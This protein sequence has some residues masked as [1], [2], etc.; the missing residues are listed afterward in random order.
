MF[1]R[2]DDF[3]KIG[4]LSGK[5]GQPTGRKSKSFQGAAGRWFCWQ[6]P[7]SDRMAT[8]DV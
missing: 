4:Y 2:F 8:L 7:M 5:P 1:G 3:T 6:R